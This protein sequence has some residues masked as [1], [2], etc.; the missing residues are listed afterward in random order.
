MSD[1]TIHCNG[2]FFFADT[3]MIV[4]IKKSIFHISRLDLNLQEFANQLVG[5]SFI[6]HWRL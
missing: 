1:N 5:F 6:C 3:N 4:G 2:T